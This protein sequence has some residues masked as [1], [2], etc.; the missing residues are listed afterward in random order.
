MSDQ[1]ADDTTSDEGQSRPTFPTTQEERAGAVPGSAEATAVA[2]SLASAHGNPV[3][4]RSRFP[5]RKKIKRK[6][7]DK[8]SCTDQGTQTDK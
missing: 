4:E 2:I 7:K 3:V 8:P 1:I 5:R 6:K